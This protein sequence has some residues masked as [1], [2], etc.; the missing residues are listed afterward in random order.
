MEIDPGTH[1]LCTR[2]C[3]LETGVTRMSVT[4]T[5]AHVW[6]GVED[7]LPGGELGREKVAQARLWFY[8]F[9][10]FFNSLFKF[11]TQVFNLNFKLLF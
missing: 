4:W 9:F 7:G 6:V 2:L 5:G 10:L 11:Q 8:I 1:M 3:P